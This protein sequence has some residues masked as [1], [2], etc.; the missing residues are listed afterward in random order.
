M[1]ADDCLVFTQA[2]RS[3]DR[4]AL[5]LEDYHKGSGQLVNKGKSAVFFSENCEDEVRLEVMDG[6]Q[7][8]IEALG[9]KYL[10]LPTAVGKVADGTFSYVADRIRSFVN[11]WSEKDLSCAAR[12]V[13]VKANAQAV[14][15]YPMSCFKLPV[16]VCKRMTSYISNYWWGSA[17]DSHKIHWQRWSKLTCPKGEG[18]MGFRDLLL[19]NKALL[20]KQGWRLLARPDALCTRVIKGKYFPHGNFL[21]ATRK[22]KS[23]ETWRAM[24]YGREILKKG[25][26]KRIGS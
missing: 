21:T 23:S 8:T 3:A 13:L 7:I 4:L 24:L 6:L 18:G 12:E 16:D 25:L 9:E 1:F 22:K 19:F 11:G 5:I 26:I 15:T 17:V 10:G 20:G 14:P 2:T